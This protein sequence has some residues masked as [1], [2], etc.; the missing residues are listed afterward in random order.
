MFEETYLIKETALRENHLT[1][2]KA[3]TVKE[4]Q[5]KA[6][7]LIFDRWNGVKRG[8]PRQAIMYRDDEE[9][10]RLRIEWKQINPGA[11]EAVACIVY[12]F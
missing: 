7:Q 9:V 8:R 3:S 2:V 10:C 4:A 6:G 1:A 11:A 12:A 5:K